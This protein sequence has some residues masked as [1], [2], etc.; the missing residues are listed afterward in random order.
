METAL[1]TDPLNPLA[2]PASDGTVQ[3]PTVVKT[4]AGIDRLAVT[5]SVN[6]LTGTAVIVEFEQNDN[7]KNGA[8]WVPSGVQ[9][10]V[11]ASGT[12]TNSVPDLDVD[13]ILNVR[14]QKK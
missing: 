10:V 1:G 2:M 7:L 8:G 4:V 13:G 9:R 12:Y 3:A 6:L 14:I 5:F 11:T